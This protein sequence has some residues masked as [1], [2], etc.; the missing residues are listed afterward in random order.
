MKK[1]IILLAAIISF[2]FSLSAQDAK[3]GYVNTNT[4]LEGMPK[5]KQLQANLEAYATQLENKSKQLL[6]TYQKK[7]QD[8]IAKKES[9]QLSP[10]QEQDQ[11]KAL[12]DEEARI[13]EFSRDSQ[14]KLQ[15]RQAE[16][17]APVE[18]QIFDIV[19]K[20]AEEEGFTYIIN[21][22]GAAGVILYA[23]PALDITAKV[24]ARL[25]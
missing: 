13:I 3:V 14:Q 4:I 22:G 25:N 23:N 16:L 11:L 24:Q 9:G 18:T 12:Q 1:F 6:D 7:Q 10:V 20:V 2:N 19:N 5:V 8:F 21:A 17:F 15:E